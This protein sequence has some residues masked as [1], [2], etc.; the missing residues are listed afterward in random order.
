MTIRTLSLLALAACA[1]DPTSSAIES[2]STDDCS[3]YELQ[4]VG[5]ANFNTVAVDP[6]ILPLSRVGS[7]I[8]DDQIH[9][10]RMAADQGLHV[11]NKHI[12]AFMLFDDQGRPASIL[13]GGFYQCA[14]QADCQSYIDHVV[15]GYVLA[16]VPFLDRP[17]FH[18]TFA[19]HS[20]E[21]LGAAQF[22]DVSADYAIKITRWRVTGDVDPRP[23][24]RAQWQTH[25]R[26]EAC[27]RGTLTQAHVL[28]SEAEHVIAEVTIGAKVDPGGPPYFVSTLGALAAQPPLNT[29][30]DQLPWLTRIPP[31]VTDTYLVLTYWPGFADPGSW[32][33][34]PST[35]PGGPLPEPFC[36]DGTCNTTVTD[37]ETAASC[38]SDCAATCG[39]GVC[40]GGETDV[41]CAIDCPP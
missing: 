34:S 37:I 32:P 2:A 13:A 26:A 33:N 24:I 22:A 25:A 17:E 30:F 5:G 19:T 8:A 10:L 6:N 29:V 18:G 4:G 35:T 9:M 21:D 28:Y 15:H 23:L 38:P 20:Y 40:D 41:T 1:G 39:N 7:V 12:P 27:H 36:G 3:Q 16:G 14:T 11:L 31:E